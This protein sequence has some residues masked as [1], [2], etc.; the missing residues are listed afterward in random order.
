MGRHQTE[1]ERLDGGGNEHLALSW[2]DTEPSPIAWMETPMN[3]EH[4]H[5]E[6]RSDV[7][8]ELNH[9]PAKRDSRW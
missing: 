6:E 1:P 9:L 2:R 8:I 4:C 3:T 5:R 7:A